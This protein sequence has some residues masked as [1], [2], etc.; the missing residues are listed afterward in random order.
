MFHTDGDVAQ[1][2]QSMECRGEY[3]EQAVAE[4]LQGITPARKL[5]VK[6]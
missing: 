4:A 6:K 1:R 2:M 3:V 5:C